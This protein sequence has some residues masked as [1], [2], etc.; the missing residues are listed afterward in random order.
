MK[1]YFQL[2]LFLFSLPGYAQPAGSA[3]SLRSKVITLHRFLDQNHYEPVKWNDT[4]SAMLYNRWIGKLDNEK[5]F[6]TQNE[7][8]LLETYKTKL[9]DE[10]LGKGWEF[11]D[12]SITLY[13]NSLRRTDSL[14]KVLL[15]KPF[16]FSK[17]DNVSWPFTT[18]ASSEADLNLRWQKFL[19][20]RALENIADK[21]SDGGKIIIET[22]PTNFVQLEKDA[23]EKAKKQEGSFMLA[24]L[25]TTEQ[26]KTA[27]EDD[28]LNTIAWCYDPHTSYMSIRAKKE[29]DTQMSAS[30]FSAGFELEE[31]DKG[32][33][34][35]SFLQPGGSA[36]RSGQ[37][38]TGDQLI[39]LKS[40][41]IEK[42]ITEIDNEVILEKMLGGN[43]QAELEVTVKTAAGELKTVKL[44]K[45]KID[46]EEGIV[47]SYV[48]HGNKNIGYINLPGFYSREDESI[49]DER[50]IKYDGSAND[51]SKE[52]VKLRKDTIAG[53]ILDLRYNGGGSMWEAMQLAGI[54][55]DIGPVASVKEKDGKVRFLKDPNRGTIYDGPL[56]VLI[57]GASA[58]ASEFVSAVLQDYNRALIVG[59]T[60]YGKGTAQVVLPMDT[61]SFSKEKNYEEFVKVTQRKF[62]R[63]NGNTTQWTGVVP[64]VEL[65]DLYADESYREKANSSALQPD[66]SKT[67][68]YQPA[69]VLPL[70]TLKFKS[71]Q[72]ISGDSYF[73]TIGAFNRWMKEYK[74][75]RNIP[76][77]WNSYALHYKKI[78]SMFKELSNEDV[79]QKAVLSVTNNEFDRQRINAST[80]H[81]KEN[82]EAYVKHVQQDI[83]L[84]E[85]YKIMMDW[86]IK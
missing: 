54:F 47:K 39:K 11:Y 43:S 70:Q 24:L 57:N 77:Q 28:Y 13:K 60:T 12:K 35:I 82:N 19:K 37:L 79:A 53:L 23:R 74:S 83:T 59:G 56:M 34:A 33:L 78:L 3:T 86:I 27:M 22:L 32:D 4:S 8:A 62:Y 50:D 58:S 73:N 16:D 18:Y 51:V 67:G 46:S 84:A 5:L 48:L 29:F 40:D 25:K 75:G 31:N 21:L 1:I 80:Q 63:V 61:L 55:I 38:H 65:P 10:I 41:G 9:D 45:E 71:A 52:I 69:A 81:S 42:E 85:A 49:T 14:L 68:I 7:I 15:A 2:L 30:E 44:R 20:W 64:D 66:N 76:L 6:F 26:F 36:W 17:P 72:R